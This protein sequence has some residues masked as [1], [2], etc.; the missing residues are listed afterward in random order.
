MVLRT[1]TNIHAD[2]CFWIV[3][4]SRVFISGL[5]EDLGTEVVFWFHVEFTFA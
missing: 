5:E 1:T 4:Y 3:W 2:H